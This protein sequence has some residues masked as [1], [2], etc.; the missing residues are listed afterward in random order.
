MAVSHDLQVM[1]PS[2]GPQVQHPQGGQV[3]HSSSSSQGN[4]SVLTPVEPF[5]PSTVD[6]E[7]QPIAGADPPGFQSFFQK[8]DACD[9][10]D[11]PDKETYKGMMNPRKR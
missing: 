4:A 2:G 10:P 11:S 7:M 9:N 3:T 6:V 1:S 8:S 5:A